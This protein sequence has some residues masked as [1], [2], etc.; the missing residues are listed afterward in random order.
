MTASP[1]VSLKLLL[2]ERRARVVPRQGQ[3]GAPFVGPGVD[4]L[5]ERFETL[6]RL[7]PP[8]FQWFSARE[9]G[10]AL[11]SLSLDF[12]SPRLLATYFPAGVA[13]GDKP[14]VMRVDAPQVYELLTLAS[15]LS[16]AARRE[17]LAVAALRDAATSSGA[18]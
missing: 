3:D 6:V 12:V 1:L 9:P 2:H 4:L 10:I 15:P 16:D 14:F 7:C 8:L 11:R 13:E 5:N 17:A 18:R